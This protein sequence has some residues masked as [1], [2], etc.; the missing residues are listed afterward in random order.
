MRDHITGIV[1][2]CNT[3]EYL[4]KAIETVRM[5]E[6]IDIILI[7]GSARNSNGWVVCKGLKSESVKV[8]Q[9]G[10]NIGHG[11]GINMAMAMVT[12]KYALLF[13]SDIEML[14]PCLSEMIALMDGKYGC[15][16]IIHT[17]MNGCNSVTGIEYLHPHFALIDVEQF[18][19]YH[20]CVHHGAPMIK[21]MR[22]LSGMGLLVDFPVPQYVKHHGRAT[23][24]TKPREFKS[25]QWDKI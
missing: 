22:E 6:D 8:T 12:T 5:H 1:I 23:V 11:K 15:G 16:Q 2:H 13:D 3:P 19:K 25:H 17:D 14:A 18:G 4:L 10:H 24:R 7:D 9:L 20:A 21:A